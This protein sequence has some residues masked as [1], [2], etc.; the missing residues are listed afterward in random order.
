[1]EFQVRVSL[2]EPSGGESPALSLQALFSIMPLRP[3]FSSHLALP[4]SVFCCPLVAASVLCGRLRALAYRRTSSFVA[5]SED[6]GKLNNLPLPLQASG[7]RKGVVVR[8]AGQSVQGLRPRCSPL[9]SYMGSQ[10]PLQFPWGGDKQ[11]KRLL[12]Y[13]SLWIYPVRLPSQW[14]MHLALSAPY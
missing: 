14:R 4:T 3:V 1:M 11:G 10:C 13:L 12:P 2:P 7:T 8:R 9:P 6:P 5:G